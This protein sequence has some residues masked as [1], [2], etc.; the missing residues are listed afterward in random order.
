MASTNEK[1]KAPIKVALPKLTVFSDRINFKSLLLKGSCSAF[2][3][4]VV[5]YVEFTDRFGR[6]AR[7]C[8]KYI[9]ANMASHQLECDI[10]FEKPYLSE[11]TFEVAL[12]TQTGIRYMV[13]FHCESHQRLLCTYV[14]SET[15]LM[16]AKETQLCACVM[17]DFVDATKEPLLKPERFPINNC[18]SAGINTN[19]IKILTNVTIKCGFFPFKNILYSN[20]TY[21]SS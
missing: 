7:S 3:A 16:N 11:S 14:T 12:L 18:F 17:K 21:T 19:K 10:F 2:P 6:K 8:S 5:E 4:L 15:R 1:I 13:Q 9:P 20:R